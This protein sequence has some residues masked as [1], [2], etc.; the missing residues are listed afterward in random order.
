MKE[1]CTVNGY[2]EYL[3]DG[4]AMPPLQCNQSAIQPKNASTPR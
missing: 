2:G 1:V 3:R 4:L